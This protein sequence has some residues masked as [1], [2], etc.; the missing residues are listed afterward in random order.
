MTKEEYADKIAEEYWNGE[1]SFDVSG[2]VKYQDMGG[3]N[4]TYHFTTKRGLIEQME[5]L[6]LSPQGNEI[7]GLIFFAKNTIEGIRIDKYFVAIK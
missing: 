6:P 3:N 7:L 5:S 2:A 4:I 1:D